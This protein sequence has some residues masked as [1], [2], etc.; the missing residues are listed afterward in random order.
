MSAAEDK[1]L[2]FVEIAGFDSA[3]E[4]RCGTGRIG[5]IGRS[6]AAAL[7]PAAIMP[8]AKASAA[9]GNR[10]LVPQL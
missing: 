7:A 1:F 3:L 9:A 6:S 4:Y 2:K 10:S 5:R 8:S